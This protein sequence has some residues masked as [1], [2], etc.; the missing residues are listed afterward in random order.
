MYLTLALYL[1]PTK[2]NYITKT[3]A[4]PSLKLI[5]TTTPAH[6]RRASNTTATLPDPKTK[7]KPF[8]KTYL[9]HNTSAARRASDTTT[10]LHD[11]K[12][13]R[14]SILKTHHQHH[15]NERSQTE[16]LNATNNQTKN[17]ANP[18]FKSAL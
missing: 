6:A 12:I 14:K 11:P 10:T 2:T 8:L 17:P 4:T 18:S 15:T 5:P 16:W 7:R 13:K 9:Y 1:F 3:N